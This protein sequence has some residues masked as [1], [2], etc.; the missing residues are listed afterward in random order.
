MGMHF[1]LDPIGFD[2]DECGSIMEAGLSQFK[3]FR[4]LVKKDI[5]NMADEFGKRSIAQGRIVFSLGRT[6]KLTGVTHWVQDCFRANN[7]PDHADF[8]EPSLYEALSLAQTRKSHIDLVDTNTK[9][10][11]PGKFKDKRKWPEWEK[12]FI[13]YLLVI[14]GMS[15][16]PL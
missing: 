4:Y 2:K 10:A 12:A 9:A 14:P 8:N 7:V 5:R 1:V 3:D 6:K 16:I 13:N 11:N 15:G